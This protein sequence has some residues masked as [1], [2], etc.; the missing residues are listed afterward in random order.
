MYV[1]VCLCGDND[2]VNEEININAHVDRDRAG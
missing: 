1:C 2:T